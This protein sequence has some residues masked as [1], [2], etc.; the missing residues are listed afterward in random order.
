[1]QGGA[2]AEF[3]GNCGQDKRTVFQTG[4]NHVFKMQSVGAN[5]G[6]YEMRHGWVPLNQCD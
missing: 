1:M 5:C 4:E 3:G 6:E 2:S